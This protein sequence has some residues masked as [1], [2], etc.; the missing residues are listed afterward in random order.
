M[1][2]INL[3]FTGDTA[4][5]TAANNLLAAL[6]DNHVHHGNALDIDVRTIAWKR[7]LDT[8]DRAARRRRRPQ[9]PIATASPR[10]RLRHRRSPGADG[11]LLPDRVMG[12]PEAPHRRDR[13]RYSRAGRRHRRRPGPR[14]RWR[15][16]CATHW[17]RTSCQTLEGAGVRARRP[18]RQHRHGCSSVMA[19]R[20]ALRLADI[21]VTE[22]GS[23]PTSAPRSSSTSSAACR[24]LRPDVAVVVAT[25]RAEVP[26]R[27]CRWATSSGRISRLSRGAWSTCADTCNIREGG[28]P[29]ASSPSTGLSDTDLEVARVVEPVESDGRQ[30]AWRR[31]RRRRRL[32]A[33]DLGEGCPPGSRRPVGVVLRVHLPDDLALVE[34][35]GGGEP[36][37]GAGLAVVGRQGASSWNSAS[38]RTGLPRPPRVHRQDQCSFSTDP[39][40]LGAPTGHELRVRSLARGGRRLVVVICGDMMTMPGLPAAGGARIDLADDGTILNLS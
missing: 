38:S 1:T 2:D 6:I 25:V 3:N 18:L 14:V 21:V 4:A 27:R 19:T 23:A 24:G 16:C 13:H 15:S 39:T 9:R 17:R 12:R 26:R 10:G 8:N 31:A 34:G 29:R 32:G 30:C 33:Q 40:L 35:R 28:H 7:V 11:D 36:R 37:G 22:A 5:L 20:S